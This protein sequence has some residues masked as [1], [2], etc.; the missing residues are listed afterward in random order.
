MEAENL[1]TAALAAA[2]EQG[3]LAKEAE[4][5][6]VQRAFDDAARDRDALRD[7]FVML[8]VGAERR[9]LVFFFFFFFCCCCCCI[10]TRIFVVGVAMVS[11]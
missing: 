8:Q 4:A 2:I 7:T 9:C 5:A 6:E 10:I 3:I 11:V 1:G